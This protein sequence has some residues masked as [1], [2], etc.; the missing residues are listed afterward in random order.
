MNQLPKRPEPAERL[1]FPNTIE[2]VVNH[3]L[4]GKVTPRLKELLRAEG[5][6]LDR[7]LR[8]AYPADAWSRCLKLIALE[9]YPDRPAEESFRAMGSSTLDGFGETLWGRALLTMM[10]LLGP[11]RLLTRLQRDI[12]ASDNFTNL[13]VTELEKTHVEISVNWGNAMPGYVEGLLGSLML[14]GGA[15]NPVVTHVSTHGSDSIYR[16]RWEE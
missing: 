12:R 16:I 10:R 15:R 14:A 11:R 6:D 7:P 3:V 1:N 8:P 9:L 5:V 2:G 13:V 4:K